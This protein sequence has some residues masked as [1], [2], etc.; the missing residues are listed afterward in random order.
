MRL[1]R[2][3]GVPLV[4]LALITFFG[5][6]GYVAIEG[7]GWIDALYMSV[8]TVSTVG[9]GE[10]RELSGPGRLF[11]MFLIVSGVGAA[12]YLLSILSEEVLEGQLRRIFRR[13]AMERAI[14]KLEGH[15]IVCGYGRFGRVVAREIKEAG[16]SAVVIDE[17]PG[18][19]AELDLLGVPFVIGSAASDEVLERAHIEHASALVVATSSEAD[20]VFITLAARELN[21]GIRVY[22]RGESEAGVRRLQRAGADQV[23]SPFQMGGARVAAAI[24][25][26]TI[27]NFAK[28]LYVKRR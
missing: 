9:F 5:A 27:S 25:K 13:S 28:P 18:R 21:P 12:L 17:D 7:W 14:Q 15:V 10:V 11:T 20:G 1:H 26:D 24:L 22:A 2:K 23:T 4:G 16:R 6:I 8:I 3:I 19:E